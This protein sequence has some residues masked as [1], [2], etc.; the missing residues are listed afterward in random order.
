MVKKITL[1]LLFFILCHPVAIIEAETE[2]KEAESD[3]QNVNELTEQHLESLGLKEITTYWDNLSQEY[4]VFLPESQKGSLKEFITGDKSFQVTEW[5]SA[6]LQYVFHEIIANGQL[7]G[8]LLLLAVFSAILKALQ[9]AFEEESVSKVAYAVIFIVLLIIAL[10]SFY[11]AMDYVKDTVA[12]MV[13]F[14]IALLPLMLALLASSGSI[15]AAGLFHPLVILLVQSSGVLIQYIILPFLFFSAVLSI[16]SSLN[17]HVKVTKLAELLRNAAMGILAVF[18]TVFLGV[19]SVQGA[20]AAVTDG[21][22]IRTTKFL[23]GNFVPVIGR[24]FTDAADTALGASVLLKNTIGLAGV[25]ILFI[26]CAFPA[27]KILV[28]GFIFHLTAALIQP[29]GEGALLDALSTLG[30]T[31]FSMFAALAAVS[32]MFFLAL[33]L[34]IASGNISLMVR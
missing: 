21:V 32:F 3:R 7:M 34:I 30:K 14:M 6:F 5:M 20:T 31:V 26:I 13:H 19:I 17:E 15:A 25:G 22:A 8:T 11:I 29:L 23:A 28:I 16:V 33:T 24:M 12:D 9:N 4:G 1:C 10:N 2:H 27:I 18:F